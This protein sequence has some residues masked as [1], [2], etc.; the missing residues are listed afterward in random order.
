MLDKGERESEKERRKRVGRVSRMGRDKNATDTGRSF[1]QVPE[2][3]A[4]IQDT[5][6]F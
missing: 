3:S 6:W 2:T 4:G 1:V 5:H